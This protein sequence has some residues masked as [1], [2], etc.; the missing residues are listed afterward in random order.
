VNG[1]P[2]YG[3]LD[4]ATLSDQPGFA[5]TATAVEH[6]DFEADD[7]ARVTVTLSGSGAVDNLDF[8]AGRS[9]G[10]FHGTQVPRRLR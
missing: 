4:L 6:P 7:L 3:T 9:L 8:E 5:A 2:G 10:A 1:P